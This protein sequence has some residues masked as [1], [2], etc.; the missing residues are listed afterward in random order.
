MLQPAPTNQYRGACGFFKHFRRVF[1]TDKYEQLQGE[2]GS[3][4]KGAA[5]G[6]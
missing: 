3:G 1:G 4:R 5:I 6:V 2:K